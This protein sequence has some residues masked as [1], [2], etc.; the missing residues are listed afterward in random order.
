VKKL[1]SGL[2]VGVAM[3]ALFWGISLTQKRLTGCKDLPRTDKLKPYLL[4]FESTFANYL[5]IRTMLYFGAHYNSDKDYRWLTGMVDMVTRL[6]P[7]FYPAYEFAG[8]MLPT[9][10]NN[11][12]A[13]RIILNRGIN[14]LTDHHYHLYFYLGWLYYNSYHD[15][16]MAANYLSI[17]AGCDKAPPYI[18]GL[19]A[20]LYARA[21]RKEMAEEFLRSLYQTSE[22]PAVRRTIERKI[23]ALVAPL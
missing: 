19:V 12:D 3:L 23:A 11:P 10:S 6:N 13:A 21:G 2:V 9:Y 1:V 16:E 22:N 14:H 18:T 15:L 7:R 8:L 4:G 17:A 5:W 20:T